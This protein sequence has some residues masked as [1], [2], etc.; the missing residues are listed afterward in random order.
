MTGVVDR[1]TRD[2]AMRLSRESKAVNAFVLDM[3]CLGSIL[4]GAWP[5]QLTHAEQFEIRDIFGSLRWHR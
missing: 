3:L 2:V 5:Y 1:V 4:G